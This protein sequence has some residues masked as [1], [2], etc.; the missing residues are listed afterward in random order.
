MP[1]CRRSDSI[2]APSA[3]DDPKGFLGRSAGG[4]ILDGIAA[5]WAPCFWRVRSARGL[6]ELVLASVGVSNLRVG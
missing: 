5:S 3:R 2:A 4:V 1:M 6:A